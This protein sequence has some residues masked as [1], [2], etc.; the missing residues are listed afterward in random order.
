MYLTSA[1]KLQKLFSETISQI[2]Y[3]ADT[4]ADKRSLVPLVNL[5]QLKFTLK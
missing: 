3:V 5:V 4:I 2:S 1:G